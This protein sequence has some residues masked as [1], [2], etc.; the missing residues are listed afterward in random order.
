MASTSLLSLDKWADVCLDISCC[1][2]ADNAD[3]AQLV[4][5]HLAKVRVAGSSPVIRSE[6]GIA[7]SMTTCHQHGGLAERRGNGLQS[8]VHGFESRTHLAR[9]I[10]AAGA[11]FLDT[12]EVTGSIPVSPTARS[13]RSKRAC[14]LETGAT[15]A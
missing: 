13:G 3:V 7:S 2:K 9:A 12:E 11:R 5:H 10:G 6:V 14:S 4:E 15:T 8:R 1:T